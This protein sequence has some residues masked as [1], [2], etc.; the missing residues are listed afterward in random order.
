MKRLLFDTNVFVYA[1]GHP[2]PLR[3]PCISLLENLVR[4][5]LH[6]EVS[7]DLI[8]EF[9]HQRHRQTRDRAR[10]AADARDLADIVT[11]HD[12]TLADADMGLSL[13][14]A[15]AGLDPIDALFAATALR[16]GI[17]TIVSADRAFEG[18]PGLR[19]VDPLDEPAVAALRDV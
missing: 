4:S 1:L 12:V 2:H 18:I 10:A 16:R 8:Q 14:A 19:R 7:A 3:E 17:D 11:V 6:G 9:C 13:Y 5:A 15:S